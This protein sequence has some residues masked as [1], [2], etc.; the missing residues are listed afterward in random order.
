MGQYIH[1]D[2]AREEKKIGAWF[3]RPLFS[4]FISLSLW[5]QVVCPAL[6][7]N[8]QARWAC[9]SRLYVCISKQTTRQQT[10]RIHLWSL[11]FLRFCTHPSP[12]FLL[13]SP[14]LFLELFVVLGLDG[15]PS[16][17]AN[18][19]RATTSK[20][21]AKEKEGE[22]EKIIIHTTTDRDIK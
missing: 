5:H 2:E 16:P 9:W 13:P 21:K 19:T 22:R 7:S 11:Y 14:M 1:M 15:V 12:C 8:P 20:S 6:S 4:F 17:W 3:A 10:T 18:S